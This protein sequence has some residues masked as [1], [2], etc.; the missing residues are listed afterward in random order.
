M[1]KSAEVLGKEA[2][3]AY[4]QKEAVWGALAG[5]AGRGLAALGRGALSLGGRA[6]GQ[7]AGMSAGQ[8]V[9]GAATSSGA[10]AASYA[11]ELMGRTKEI[12]NP[13][14]WKNTA[15]DMM[16]QGVQAANQL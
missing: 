12:A 8:R 14:Q 3:T 2:A 11:P 1:I 10:T 13:N 4:L 5:L 15:K 9:L 16:P 6:L 7:R